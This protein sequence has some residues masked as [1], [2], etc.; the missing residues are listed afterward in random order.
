ML[1][2]KHGGGQ[3]EKG[4]AVVKGKWALLNDRF[5]K[6]FKPFITA[7]SVINI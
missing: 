4:K 3:V 6:C 1:W 5:S 2:L 7:V